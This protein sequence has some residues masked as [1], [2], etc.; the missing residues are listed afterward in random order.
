MQ[1]STNPKNHPKQKTLAIKPIALFSGE[2]AIQTKQDDKKLL[3]Y[4]ALNL[5]LF[6]Q[7]QVLT[8]SFFYVKNQPRIGLEII[9]STKN[10]LQKNLKSFFSII[11]PT[12]RI[13]SF[14]ILFIRKQC[15]NIIFNSILFIFNIYI[16]EIDFIK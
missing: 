9:P 13:L 2:K 14:F 6:K 3:F 5:Q 8:I 12:S 4:P 15:Y 7:Q 11:K 16:C 1:K 10:N